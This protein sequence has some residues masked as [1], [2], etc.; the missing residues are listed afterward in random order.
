MIKSRATFSLA[1]IGVT[2]GAAVA[3]SSSD[4]STS[5]DPSDVAAPDGSA[6]TSPS[7]DGAAARGGSSP[8]DDGDGGGTASDAGAKDAAGDAPSIALGVTSSLTVTEAR[9]GSAPTVHTDLS[10]LTTTPDGYATSA[11]V[12]DDTPMPGRV[13]RIFALSCSVTAAGRIW[14]V[15]F[16]ARNFQN[17]T[18][19]LDK[20]ND[21]GKPFSLITRVRSIG[22]VTGYYEVS[23]PVAPYSG[24]VTTTT[25]DYTQRTAT[26]SL[27]F[28]MSAASGNAPV[29]TIA[30]TFAA[31]W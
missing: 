27:R 26:G 31:A 7:E 14:E 5:G 10:C 25:L 13:D 6:S 1:F 19:R 4:P 28:E 18:T 23:T 17:G 30:G 16:V 8:S 24:S 15:Q 3:C 29:F 9:A 2:L 20:S 21:P 11:N 22:P 12:V